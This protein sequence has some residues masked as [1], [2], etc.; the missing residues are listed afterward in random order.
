MNFL[1][2]DSFEYLD[3][4]WILLL[5]ILCKMIC[6][7]KSQKIYFSNIE[8][9]SKASGKTYLFV[10]ILKLMIL[11][12]M[13]F[14]LASPIKTKTMVSSQG[15]GHEIA[16]ILDASGSMLENNKFESTKKIL[17]E[18]I[19]KRPNDLISLSVFAD[20]AY[21][22]T[23]LSFDK[24]IIT[25]V[26]KFTEVGVAGKF[27]TALYE[28][29]FLS[30]NL[31]KDSKSKNKIAILITDGINSAESVP[32]QTAIKRAKKFSIKVY[33]VAIGKKGDFNS[34]VL[35]KIANE[36]GGKFFQ[37]SSS[38]EL[39][40]IYETINSLEKSQIKTTKFTQTIY[41]FQYPAY[42][43]IFFLLIYI[44]IQRSKNDF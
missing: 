25:S 37:G 44:L 7:E 8:M 14:A 43:G 41:Y 21:V 13:V 31:F 5:Y 39:E 34:E 6:K 42:L 4:F 28:A 30:S 27:E 23:P 38:S 35:R 10:E 12:C 29:L 1:G 33:S 16:L 17:Y 2:F 19:K 3:V 36:T 9:I 26:L 32:L 20:Y 22:A 24:T 11:F 40:K 15:E 18:F